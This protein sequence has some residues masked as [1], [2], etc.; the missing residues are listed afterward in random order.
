VA[1]ISD[2]A[3]RT[4]SASGIASN[5]SASTRRVQI[6]P[7]SCAKKEVL[8]ILRNEGWRQPNSEYSLDSVVLVQNAMLHY[9]ADGVNWHDA[10]LKD[11]VAELPN[12]DPK[13]S[14]RYALRVDLTPIGANASY[15]GPYWDMSETKQVWLNNGGN[16]YRT[17]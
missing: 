3:P 4:S 14:L 5:A 8:G 7:L 1:R 2:Q 11:G 13:A 16:D 10:Q 17:W 9:T 12:V 6:N 15:G